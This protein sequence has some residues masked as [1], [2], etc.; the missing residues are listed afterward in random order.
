MF[1]GLSSDSGDTGAT[2]GQVGSDMHSMAEV[3][4]TNAVDDN[5]MDDDTAFEDAGD[6]ELSSDGW[7]AAEDSDSDYAAAAVDEDLSD[8]DAAITVNGNSEDE[9]EYY[10][11]AIDE[12]DATESDGEAG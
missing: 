3:N 7:E 4:D 5:D 6:D 9:R 12:N 1:C 8:E 10:D 11:E 2:A